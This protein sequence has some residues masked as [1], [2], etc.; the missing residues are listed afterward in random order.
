MPILQVRGR[1]TTSQQDFERFSSSSN[2]Q[3]YTTA[4][5]ENI[6]E[7]SIEITLGDGWNDNYSNSD[8]S[9]RQIDESI[10]IRGHDSIVVEINEEVRIPHNRYG[11]V[12]PTGSLFLAQ[13]VLIASAKVEPAFIG[14]L[15]LRLF[16]TTGKKINLK[17]DT[18]L[19]SIIFFP[20]ESTKVHNHT[21]R[22]SD[23]SAPPP[24]KYSSTLKWFGSNKTT[25]IGWLV[26]ILSSWLL[27]VFTYMIYYEPALKNAQAQIEKSAQ[28]RP[29][30]ETKT[31][32]N[33]TK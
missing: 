6:E 17:K 4:L 22:A 9:L 3:I 11:I 16:N 2:S 20:T 23:I 32:P 8:R 13:G 30:V 24:S 28:T 5:E 18:K 14:K 1:T 31:A 21:Y 10:T 29:A 19:G 12:L 33:Q 7:F 15:K 26:T 27:V 25:W